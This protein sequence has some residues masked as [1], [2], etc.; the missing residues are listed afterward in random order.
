[1]SDQHSAAENDRKLANIVRLGHVAALDEAGALVR[2]ESGGITTDWL[3]WITARAGGDRTWH[4]PEVGEQV[5][6]LSP[7]GDTGQGVVLPSIYQTSSGAP[8]T[9][10]DKHRT[11]YSDGAY[12]E[13]DRAAHHYTISV[14]GGVGVTII[15]QTAT[16]QA[17]T[18]VQVQSP[19]TTITGH[20]TIQGG[21]A[22]SGG[23]GATVSGSVAVTGGTVSADGIDIKTHKHT[24]V[25]SGLSNTGPSTP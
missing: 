19:E 24:G 22:V 5:V 20:V 13:Y 9:S 14:P 21:L 1:M 8:A 15:C 16:I 25:T 6:I 11:Q 10:K 7:S 18:S 17:A 3:P 23:G 12:M 4:A 2:V